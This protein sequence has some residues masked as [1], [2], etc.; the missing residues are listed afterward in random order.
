[1]VGGLHTLIQNRIMKPLAIAWSGAG[2]RPR[3]RDIGGDLNNTIYL[4]LS[5]YIKLIWDCHNESSP[6]NECI[7]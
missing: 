6:C 2:R 1:M 5:L 4:G 3:E 7:S